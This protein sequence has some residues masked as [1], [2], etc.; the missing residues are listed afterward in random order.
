MGKRRVRTIRFDAQEFRWTGAIGIRHDE[1]DCRR[2]V[3]LRV[4]GSAGRTGQVLDVALVSAGP[5]GPWGA[6]TD[7]VYPTPRD[8]RTVIEYA[9][10][11]GWDPAARGGTFTLGPGG[12]GESEP[13]GLTDFT[14]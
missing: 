10:A 13:I 5:Q 9:L 7:N 3:Q 12:E 2:Y 4:W 14:L 1:S 6:C 11:R 8:V